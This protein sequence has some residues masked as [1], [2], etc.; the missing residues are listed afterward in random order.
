MQQPDATTTCPAC[1]ARVFWGLEDTQGGRNTR[2]M[3]FDLDVPVYGLRDG[4][5]NMLTGEVFVRRA[6]GV[7]LPHVFACPGARDGAWP[8]FDKKRKEGKRDDQQQDEGQAG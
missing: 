7:W 1:G 3:L 5:T 8:V 4:E 2:R 6:E